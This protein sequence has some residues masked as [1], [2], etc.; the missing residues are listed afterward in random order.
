M[1]AVCN[2]ILL[3]IFRIAEMYCEP[4]LDKP[5]KIIR[6]EQGGVLGLL[7]Y[8]MSCQFGNRCFDVSAVG[9]AQES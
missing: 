7:W 3:K 9:W 8:L 5:K 2:L 4:N 1:F 6:A